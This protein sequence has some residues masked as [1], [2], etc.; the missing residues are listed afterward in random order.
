[1]ADLTSDQKLAKEQAAADAR[2]AWQ[3]ACGL[4][5]D[6]SEARTASVVSI[7]LD[8]VNADLGRLEAG[9][10]VCRSAHL[11]GSADGHAEA[12]AL[13]ER[14]IERITIMGAD[15]DADKLD[16]LRRNLHADWRPDAVPFDWDHRRR[17]RLS[18]WLRR[19]RARV[20]RLADQ[21]ST[22]PAGMQKVTV[23]L[24]GR[25]VGEMRYMICT[26]CRLAVVGKV[27]VSGAYQG[28]NLGTR[29][30]THAYVRHP[31]YEWRTT[32]QYNTSGTFWPRMARRTGAGFAEGLLCL[33]MERDLSRG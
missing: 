12:A 18:W 2:Y 14:A 27:D 11:A 26:E 16:Q 3:L 5:D 1:M 13:I 23:H 32:A 20:A 24:A 29:L 6:A 31:D 4:G 25:Q 7:L 21:P 28:L 33:H 17:R 9:I 15:R 19:L 8:H 10:G 22:A 30:V